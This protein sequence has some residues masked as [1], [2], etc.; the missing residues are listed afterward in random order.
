MSLAVF[1]PSLMGIGI[2]ASGLLLIADLV[3][4]W[5]P[6]RGHRRRRWVAIGT[7][8]VVS[9]A[10]SA[11]GLPVRPVDLMARAPRRRSVYVLM[12]VLALALAA[13]SV[14]FC[15]VVYNDPENLLY[16]S[17]WMP[18]FAVAGG[19]IFGGFAL[20][21]S[22]LA[23]YTPRLPTPLGRLVRSTSLGKRGSDDLVS[24]TAPYRKD[25]P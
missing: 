9:A 7:Y 21:A 23:W 11:A 18:G 5:L 2:L 20:L 6:N 14:V 12:A 24:L 1:F 13:T 17:I 19:T 22:I 10:A 8:G 25:L 15:I 4:T 16:H 3:R